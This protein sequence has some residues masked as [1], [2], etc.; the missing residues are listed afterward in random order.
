MSSTKTKV[1]AAV[2]A[3]AVGAAGLVAAVTLTDN[4][5]AETATHTAPYCL[6]GYEMRA[7]GMCYAATATTGTGVVT[8]PCASPSLPCVGDSLKVDPQSMAS[9]QQSTF[10]L[11]QAKDALKL[12]TLAGAT[13]HA[14]DVLYK[15]GNWWIAISKLLVAQAA[16]PSEL[17]GLVDTIGQRLVVT[18][19]SGKKYFAN[20]TKYKG[21]NWDEAIKVL[22]GMVDQVKLYTERP[23]N[24]TIV[25]KPPA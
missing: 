4:N 2:A 21:G 7:N 25:K 23:P 3:L 15:N 22:D 1:G 20:P 18:T 16:A 14:N 6:D 10:M 8:N 24:V 17:R 5:H 13:Y 12:T 9:P 19:I 11:V